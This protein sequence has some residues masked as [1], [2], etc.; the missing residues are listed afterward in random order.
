MINDLVNKLAEFM[1]PVTSLQCWQE[2]NTRSYPEEIN[3]A[4]VHFIFL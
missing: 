1:K 3:P 2:A 4:Q